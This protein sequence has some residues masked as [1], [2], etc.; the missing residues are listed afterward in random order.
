M[1]FLL[2]LFGGRLIQLQGL[3]A[4]ALAAQA[5][6]NRTRSEPLFARRGDILDA[7]GATLATT[8]DLRDILVD[9]T[10]VA[11][12]KRRVGEDLV[13]VGVRGAAEDLAPL[14]GQSV[15]ALTTKLTGTSR[16]AT[17]A[18]GVAP[19]VARQIMRLAIPGLVPW[20]AS[21]RVYPAGDVGGNVLGFVAAVDGSAHGG[22]EQAYDKQLA[23]TAGKLTYEQS[24]DGAQIPTGVL[25]EVDPRDG[26]TIRTTIDRDL[27]WKAQQLLAAQVS[28]LQAHGG[29]AVVLDARTFDVRA[30]AVVP[31]Y[32][33]NHPR[34][35]RPGEDQRPEPA[36]HLRARVHR[37]RSS[38]SRPPCRSRPRPRRAR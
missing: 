5:L 38:P 13:P 14:L 25:A 1:L 2:S 18:R 4:S 36:R 28:A 10:L 16:G 15:E 34:D 32:D 12:Y 22:L 3:D 11:G 17:I 7:D 37:P 24:L 27:Q 19:D 31:T 33:P 30:L 26:C 9:Q 21:R 20:Q 29:Y 6:K 23:G 8:I 35:G